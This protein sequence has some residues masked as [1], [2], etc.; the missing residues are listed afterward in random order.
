MF[1]AKYLFSLL[2]FSLFESIS[3]QNNV[4]LSEGV[5]Y[6]MDSII[7]E[8]TKALVY[9]I[10]SDYD[11]INIDYVLNQYCALVQ[12]YTIIVTK[13]RNNRKLFKRYNY[14]KDTIKSN[15]FNE[16]DLSFVIYQQKDTSKY[17]LINPVK[18]KK[19]VNDKDSR[20]PILYIG[21]PL[22]T[23]DM[24]TA[25]VFISIQYGGGCVGYEC[26]YKY[27]SGKWVLTKKTNP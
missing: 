4:D 6:Q 9:S 18:G 26:Y 5:D 2:A 24:K 23:K 25:Y 19:F 10:V 21:K 7:S 12:D 27:S 22:F 8:N 20:R 13:E 1:F 15:P 17:L 16:E 11:Y 14:R 3:A